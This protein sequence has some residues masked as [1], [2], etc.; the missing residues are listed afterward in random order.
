M[1]REDASLTTIIYY[2]VKWRT[3]EHSGGA[4]NGFVVAKNEVAAVLNM[5]LHLL[6]WFA[7]HMRKRK[8]RKSLQ[9]LIFRVVVSRHNDT[10]ST[11]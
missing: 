8:S 9:Y 4:M 3:K 1:I 10:I 6:Y 5:D 7:R 11:S 2:L